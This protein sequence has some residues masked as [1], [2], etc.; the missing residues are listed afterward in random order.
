MYEGNPKSTVAVFVCPCHTSSPPCCV[1]L[2][3]IHCQ[4]MEVYSESCIDVKNILKW[5]REFAAD[6]TEIHNEERSRRPSISDETVTKVEQTM[7]EDWWITLDD[8]CIL[9]L[10]VSEAP[11]IGF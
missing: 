11:F 2:I 5:C 8:L 3:E 7:H 6:H 1:K 4:L 9:F 10:G